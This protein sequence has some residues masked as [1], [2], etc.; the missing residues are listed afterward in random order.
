MKNNDVNL[1]EHVIADLKIS[2]RGSLRDVKAEWQSLE[3]KALCSYFQSYEWCESWFEV[4][5]AKNKITPV[6]VVARSP[7]GE[8]Q[9]ILPMQIRMRFGLRVLEWLCQPENNYGF[10]I[11]NIHNPQQ[12]YHAW[13]GNNIAKLLAALPNYDLAALENMPMHL[14][15]KANPLTT[16]SRFVSAD[17]SFFT[18]LQPDYDAL[19]ETKRTSKS[20]SKIRRRDE[21]LHELGALELEISNIYSDTPVALQKIIQH[22]SAQ[23]AEL[24]VR[25]FP[26]K[27]ITAFFDTILKN[28]SP[29][30]SLHVFRLLQSGQTISGLIGA[31]YAGTFW[32]M[33]LT[34][35]PGGPT[36]FSPGDY[37]LRKSI[38]W[39][40]DNGLKFYDFGVGY[41]NYKEH[42]ADAELQLYNYYAAKTLKGLPLAAL[43]MFYNVGKRLIKNTPFLK[44]VFFQLRK[45]LRGKKAA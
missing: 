16:L 14:L 5:G 1:S 35:A 12:D 8:T 37:V 27:N 6:I 39:A 4:F 40:C 17:Q 13:L 34:M 33:I 30:A 41:S 25:N 36:Q 44:I 42:W 11:F 20:I 9:F 10:G 28:N 32:L 7:A 43:F 3:G 24:G 21:R 45:W 26:A 38:E 19:H 18:K 31:R 23:L 29:T 22:K 15:D 2:V